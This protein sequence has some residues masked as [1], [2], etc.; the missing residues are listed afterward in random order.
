MASARWGRERAGW[1]LPVRGISSRRCGEASARTLDFPP[2][3]TISKALPRPRKEAGQKN[4]R[5]SRK[6]SRGARYT[7]PA[8]AK[9]LLPLSLLALI[10][11][12][13]SVSLTV[14]LPDQTLDLPAIQDTSGYV[15]YPAQGLEFTAVPVKGVAVSGQATAS[16]P[17]NL[18]LDIYAR[19]TSPA[20]DP[21]CTDLS[22][23]AGAPLYACSVGEADSLVGRLTFRGE[24]QAPLLLQGAVL[25]QG[26]S[27]GKFWLGGKVSGAPS[28]S[29][30]IRLTDL[31]ATATVGF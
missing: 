15:L 19:L 5:R 4:L 12:A 7:R 1:G 27:Q 10:L 2:L 31:R 22:S 21:N 24:S 16:Q 28:S 23:W 25:A 3:A 11:G 29:V 30:Q 8:M 9:R 20:G 18:D 14:P 13:C 26:V 6:R 17:L